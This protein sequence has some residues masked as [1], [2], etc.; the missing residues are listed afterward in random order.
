M[1]QVATTSTVDTVWWIIAAAAAGL[2]IAFLA[3][4]ILTSAR[5]NV[6]RT[7]LF[8]ILPLVFLVLSAVAALAIS[9]VRSRRN[10]LLAVIEEESKVP[11]ESRIEPSET[12]LT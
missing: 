4:G 9:L 6:S 3:S 10:S 12:K 1:R 11:V 8:E 5:F 2:A 7:V